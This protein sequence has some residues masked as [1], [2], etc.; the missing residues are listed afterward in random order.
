MKVA[1]TVKGCL[2]V[3]QLIT[4]HYNLERKGMLSVNGQSPGLV[5]CKVTC[6]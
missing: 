1:D 2:K 4:N 6:R 3:S 5:T